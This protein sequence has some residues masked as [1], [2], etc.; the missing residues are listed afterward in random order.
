[1]KVYVAGPWVMRDEVIPIAERI[2][3]AG[4]EI[5]HK[6]WNHEGSYDDY[7]LMREFAVLDFE[8]VRKADVVVVCD[9][10]KSEGKAVEQGIA[11]A[12]GKPILLVKRK[13]VDNLNIFHTL[14]NYYH[15]PDGDD[16]LF[17][18]ERLKQLGGNSVR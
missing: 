4:Y 2:E 18:L 17:H 15:C 11:L 10:A 16:V 3:G 12:L 6:W 7:P 9:F 1:M 14:P 8:G 5:T 13:G